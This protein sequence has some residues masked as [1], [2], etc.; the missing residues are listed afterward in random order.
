MR[1]KAAVLLVSG[2]FALLAVDTRFLH[3]FVVPSNWHGWIP[4]F[5]SAAA[6]ASLLASLGGWPAARR[7]AGWVCAGSLLVGGVGML[8]HTRGNLAEVARVLDMKAPRPAKPLGSTRATS[9]LAP[10]A[11]SGLGMV[12][13]VLVW[14]GREARR[15]AA[16]P[17]LDDERKL[18]EPYRWPDAA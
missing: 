14:P 1:R 13:F 18:R 16:A 4:V 10:L 7:L 6:S 17:P 2:G 9:S 8:C 3:R 11:L 12:G 5:Y 15:T